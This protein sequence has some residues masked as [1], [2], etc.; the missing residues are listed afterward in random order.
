MTDK[1]DILIFFSDQH[2]AGY[3]GYAGNRII[4]TPNLDHLAQK[5][6]VFD[7]AYTSC[8]LCVPARCSFMTT[9]LPSKTGIF[10]NSHAI[11]GDMPT[12]M[13]SLSAAG[14]NSV[15]CGRMHFKGY[16]HFH[17][18]DQH[19]VGDLTS[20]YWENRGRDFGEYEYWA[21]KSLG[22][23]PPFVGGGDSITLSY[24]RAVIDEALRFLKHDHEK[25]LCLVAGLHGPHPPY[26]A[27]PE[28]YQY[29]KEIMTGPDVSIEDVNYADHPLLKNPDSTIKEHILATRAAY[30]GM[31]DN[32]DRQLG[33]VRSAWEAYLKRKKKQGVFVYLSDHGDQAGERGLFAKQTFFEGSARIP[34]IFEGAGI[35]AAQRINSPCSI[36]DI[37][38]TLC[39]LT[40]AEP[41]PDSDGK[42][43]LK[44]LQTSKEDTE[45]AVFSEFVRQANFE[46]MIRQGQWKMTRDW[47]DSQNNLL[48]N[49]EADPLETRNV[50]SEYPDIAEKLR[51]QLIQDCN[52][53]E[54]IKA[55]T[56]RQRGVALLARWTKAVQPEPDA[57]WT[58]PEQATKLP[59]VY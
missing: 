13:H 25:P 20:Q 46:R 3:T 51:H 52:G 30:F 27:P 1:P 28:Y 8:P 42:S 56:S 39:E 47:N 26:V 7:S 23:T 15:L 38:P 33:M 54:I 48:F 41:I 29:Y 40:D 34:L 36:M 18:F 21:K 17:G 49:M 12:F 57:E 16:D 53:E 24:D 55:F 2:H 59:V 11:P 19:L 35:Q 10:K 45:R 32:M 37:G 4:R 14:Y 44:Q 58:I 31:I 43:L 50:F 22:V 6:T 9:K 5:G